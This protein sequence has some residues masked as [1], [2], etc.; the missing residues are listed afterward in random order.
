MIDEFPAFAVLA[1][2]A[3]GVTSVVDAAELRHKESDRIAD[4]ARELGTMG[5]AFEELPDGFRIS[6]PTRLR[7][8]VVD[9]HGD[10]RLAMALVVAGLI[11]EGTTTIQGAECIEESFPGFARIL[12][13]L[14]AEIA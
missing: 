13:G 6:G 9:S 10:H 14:G 7:G 8:A 2:Q 12:A 3:D 5:A 11:A 1:T 4:L